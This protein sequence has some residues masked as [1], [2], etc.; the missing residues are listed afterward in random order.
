MLYIHRFVSVSFGLGLV[1]HQS[2]SVLF[3]WCQKMQLNKR[4]K[5]AFWKFQKKQEL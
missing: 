1:S 5:F 3:C 2:N 4:H